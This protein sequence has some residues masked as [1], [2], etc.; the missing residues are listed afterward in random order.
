M[1]LYDI[2][3]AFRA[4][5]LCACVISSS[6]RL[7]RAALSGGTINAAALQARQHLPNVAL[8]CSQFF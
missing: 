3:A 6:H 2:T 1:L 7:L 5:L 8:V 4:L